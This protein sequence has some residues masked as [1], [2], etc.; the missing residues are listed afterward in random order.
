RAEIIYKPKVFMSYLAGINHS[1]RLNAN[2]HLITAVHDHH[3]LADD[4]LNQ[5]WSGATTAEFQS[6]PGCGHHLDML[7]NEHLSHNAGVISGI[8]N[9]IFEG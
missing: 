9:K 7:K 8:L 5:D 2:I 6:Y 4:S 3:D 1:G